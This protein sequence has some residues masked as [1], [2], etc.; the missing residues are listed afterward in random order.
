MGGGLLD[1]IVRSEHVVINP[2]LIAQL[3][4]GDDSDK[5]LE[6]CELKHDPVQLQT[7]CFLRL[8]Q[9]PRPVDAIPEVSFTKE[10]VQTSEHHAAQSQH[11]S[12]ER[13]GH[14]PFR[15]SSLDSI[16][17]LLDYVTLTSRGVESD[18]R[19]YVMIVSV[20]AI[21][22]AVLSDGRREVPWE[23]WGPAGTHIFPLEEGA[24]PPMSAG[25]FWI[26]KFLPLEVRDYDPLRT[27]YLGSIKED[28]SASSSSSSSRSVYSSTRLAVDVGEGD[29]IETHL[30]YRSFTAKEPKLRSFDKA[31]ADR[32]WIVTIL[33]VVRHVLSI[34]ITR[35]LI[36][37]KIYA[38]HR[39]RQPITP[40]IAWDSHLRTHGGSVMKK[41]RDP[42][43]VQQQRPKV[44]M[45]GF[46]Y[47][48]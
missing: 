29:E 47:A 1:G 39:I 4:S 36:L 31:V 41:Q 21:I 40:C 32:E 20:A 18:S 38:P 34:C 27:Q 5:G 30:P 24:I 19:K 22:S 8:P 9:F 17:I 35:D 45:I 44:V 48:T 25:P 46:D 42:V 37:I 16:N 15:S 10:W 43:V 33:S 6:I 12:S 7:V 3:V 2:N 14:V 13:H 23:D 26:T 28:S 11:A